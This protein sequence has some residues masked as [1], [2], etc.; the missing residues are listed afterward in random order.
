MSENI[1]FCWF[2]ALDFVILLGHSYSHEKT[3][4]GQNIVYYR[5]VTLQHSY[6]S[7]LKVKRKS[8]V[9]FITTSKSTN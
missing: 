1:L 5:P 4:D 6:T 3:E 8:T 7:K 2:Q 9:L